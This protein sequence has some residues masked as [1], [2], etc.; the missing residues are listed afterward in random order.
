[1]LRM[2]RI[3]SEGDAMRDGA[4]RVL[5]GNDLQFSANRVDSANCFQ[6]RRP[7]IG[8]LSPTQS[9]GPRKFPKLEAREAPWRLRRYSSLRVVAQFC[10]TSDRFSILVL[11]GHCPPESPCVHLAHAGQGGPMTS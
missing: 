1:M 5:V 11:H 8:G 7:G 6:K 10:F 4:K 9:P 2:F 3:D